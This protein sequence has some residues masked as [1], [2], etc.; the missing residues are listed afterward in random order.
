MFDSA[1]NLILQEARPVTAPAKD[2]A[3]VDGAIARVDTKIGEKVKKLKKESGTTE[4]K[5]T[6]LFKEKQE[7]IIT[8]SGLDRASKITPTK[9]NDANIDGGI[10]KDDS[11]S[12]TQHGNDQEAEITQAVTDEARP[13]SGVVATRGVARARPPPR[14]HRPLRPIRPLRQYPGPRTGHFYKPHAV[15]LL[16]E[17]VQIVWYPK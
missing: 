2:K 9:K 11:K 16:D 8:K 1:A 10:Q 6:N 4:D 7:E 17:T 14:S 3:D 15:M 13:T 5:S 12:V